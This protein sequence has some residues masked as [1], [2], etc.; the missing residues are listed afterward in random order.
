[1]SIFD[2][3][4]FLIICTS[5]LIVTVLLLIRIFQIK[6]RHY[7]LFKFLHNYLN[8]II[9]ARYGNLNAKIEEGEDILTKQLSKNTNA[10]FESITDRD[11][12][13]QEYI[14]KEKERQNL[15]QDFISGFAHDL[16]V[17]IIA[18]DNTYDL[19]L[20][21]NFGQLTE[22]QR[23][24]VQ[25]LK[26]SN[27]DLK[28]L[29][30][31]LLDVQKY[32]NNSLCVNK[33]KIELNQLIKE[34]LEQ[35]KS[36]FTIQN[37]NIVFKSNKK[38]IYYDLDKFLFKRVLNNLISN[39]ITHNKDIKNIEINLTQETNNIRISVIDEGKG[40]DETDINNI[41]EKYYTASKKYS[42]TSTGL[43]LYISNKIISSHGGKITA[44]NNESKGATFTIT[45]PL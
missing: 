42:N 14:E 30:L 18:Q 9:S 38:E 6:K 27:N 41:F 16:K 29:V 12:M 8:S 34:I 11:K 10:L 21:E 26:I 37:K 20:N 39:S 3:A 2:K 15:K 19:L 25:N 40:I 31:N 23:I 5:L 33:E 4:A 32:E 13:I 7:R 44:K 35:N 22:K 36:I 43:G 24:A 28:E 17:P 45:L 1:M